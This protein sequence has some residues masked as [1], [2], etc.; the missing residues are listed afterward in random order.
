M[1]SPLFAACFCLV[2]SSTYISTLKIEAV[3]SFKISVDFFRTTRR[4]IPG[5]GTLRSLICQ[6]VVSNTAAYSEKN[7]KSARAQTHT[8]CVVKWERFLMLRMVFI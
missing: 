3:L 1:S 2:S 6:N 7:M 4:E 8:H 5:D